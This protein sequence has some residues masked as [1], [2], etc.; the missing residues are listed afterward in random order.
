MKFKKKY[1][2]FS[3]APIILSHSKYAA[4]CRGLDPPQATVWYAG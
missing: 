3:K 2:C 1:G 4:G